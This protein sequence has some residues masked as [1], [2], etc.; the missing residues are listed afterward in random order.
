M[1]NPLLATYLSLASLTQL[2]KKK[3]KNYLF[4]SNILILLSQLDL[5]ILVSSM[6]ISNHI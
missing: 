3:K 2:K 1:K 6:N 5:E 4:G